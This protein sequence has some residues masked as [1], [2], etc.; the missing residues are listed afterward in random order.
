MTEKGCYIDSLP[1]TGLVTFLALVK[2][3]EIRRKRAGGWYLYLLLGDRTGEI[4]AKAWE[5]PQ[6]VAGL[7]DR[8]DIVKVRG[9]IELYN[10]RSQLIVQR[11]R[12]CEEGEFEEGDFWPAS[13]QDPDDMFASLAGFVESIGDA[14][15]RAV[16]QS[17]LDGEATGRAFRAAPGGTKLHHS[18]R[19]GLLQHTLSL[20]ELT[21]KVVDPSVAYA[22]WLL[23]RSER[24]V[25]IGLGA[26][27]QMGVLQ[28]I[29]H[30]S[31]GRGRATKYRLIEGNLP[32]RAT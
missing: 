19:G 32:K 10:E 7:F 17:I 12:R 20:C 22:A 8:D 5:K 23:G 16:L 25:Q 1:G 3:K 14:K 6:E 30:G 13:P 27:K 4:E 26:L 29:A 9:T 2:E 31:G 24:S 11:I 15:L 18:C 21:E 28:V